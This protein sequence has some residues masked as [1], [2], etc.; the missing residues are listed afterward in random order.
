MSYSIIEVFSLHNSNGGAYVVENFLDRTVAFARAKEK[1]DSWY[2]EPRPAVKL[3]SGEIYLLLSKNP[4]QCLGTV[5]EARE[6]KKMADRNVH[7]DY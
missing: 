5:L 1:G 3:E 4:V 6:Y 7:E 2:L